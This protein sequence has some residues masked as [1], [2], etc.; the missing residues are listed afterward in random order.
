MRVVIA[1]EFVFAKF[2]QG[3]IPRSN[4][5]DRIAILHRGKMLSELKLAAPLL[6]ELKVRFKPVASMDVR[7]LNG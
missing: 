6:V 5:I 4:G 7:F 1:G 3:Q 2:A